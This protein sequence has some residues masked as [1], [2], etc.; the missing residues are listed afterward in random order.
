MLTQ[1]EEFFVV[2][3]IYPNRGEFKTP[4]RARRP[5]QQFEIQ[6]LKEH[7]KSLQER[8]ASRHTQSLD[9]GQ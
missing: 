4:L 8:V 9:A 6:G 5:S 7:L 2:R 1:S 3:N